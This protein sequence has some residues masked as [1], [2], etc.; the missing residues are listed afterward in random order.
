MGIKR[1]SLLVATLAFA[2]GFPRRGERRDREPHRHDHRDGSG[3]LRPP[4]LTC[5]VGRIECVGLEETWTGGA[6]GRQPSSK[7]LS[8]FNFV[9]GDAH[10]SGTEMSRRVRRPSC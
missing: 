8:P 1:M 5:S 3:H 4:V 10:I 7:R 6:L 2:L 9:S